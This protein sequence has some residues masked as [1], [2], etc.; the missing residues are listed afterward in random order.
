MKL[1]SVFPLPQKQRWL[2][3]H[4]QSDVFL[5]RQPGTSS[6]AAA[7]AGILC[8]LRGRAASVSGTP[9]RRTVAHSVS[10]PTETHSGHCLAE[11]SRFLERKEMFKKTRNHYAQVFYIYCYF[12]LSLLENKIMNICLS[13]N[14]LVYLAI[15]FIFPYTEYDRRCL[16]F[17]YNL[18]LLYFRWCLPSHTTPLSLSL[19]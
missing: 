11:E 16:I 4:R 5:P 17:T 12:L 18:Y 1:C 3:F 19:M 14:I 10:W 8:R 2:P 13:L 15:K 9:T 6:A 7:W